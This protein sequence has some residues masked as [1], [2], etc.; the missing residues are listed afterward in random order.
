MKSVG[1]E[2]KFLDSVAPE[3][4]DLDL[5][6]RLDARFHQEG[7]NTESWVAEHFVI[8]EINEYD[9]DLGTV[10]MQSVKNWEQAKAPSA[11]AG[12]RPKSIRTGRST[13]RRSPS[14]SWWQRLLA[15]WRAP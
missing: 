8:S 15:R 13:S 12:H 7:V 6:N 2:V 10:K 9:S 1:L 4:G 14:V 5:Y 3:E 11:R